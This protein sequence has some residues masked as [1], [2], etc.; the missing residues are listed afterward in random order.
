MPGL[1][2][3]HG[4]LRG[5][6]LLDRLRDRRNVSVPAAMWRTEQPE[7]SVRVKSHDVC[8]SVASRLI[9]QLAIS[10]AGLASFPSTTASIAVMVSGRK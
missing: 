7:L 1:A 4:D 10:N 9:D 6:A 3:D 2:P 5:D 8:N